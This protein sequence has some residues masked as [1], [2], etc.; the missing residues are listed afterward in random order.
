MTV[1]KG[2]WEIFYT[3]GFDYLY[4]LPNIIRLSKSRRMRKWACGA[5]ESDEDL[6]FYVL[7]MPN[8]KTIFGT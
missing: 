7:D 4:C 5:H 3:A 8:G 6:L 1:V 2:D